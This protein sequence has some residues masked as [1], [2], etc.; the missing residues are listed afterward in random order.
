MKA[1]YLQGYNA[2]TERLSMDL[3]QPH[4]KKPAIILDL[5]ETVLDNSPFWAYTMLHNIPLPQAW[6]NKA[7]SEWVNYEKAQAVPGAKKFLDYANSRGVEIFYVSDRSESQIAATIKTLKYNKIPQAIPSHMLFRQ[8]G[9]HGKT[10]RFAELEKKYNVL[11]YFGDNLGDF[12]PIFHLSLAQRDTL[13]QKYAA[14]FGTRFIIF[15]NPIYGSWENAAYHYQYKLNYSQR[16]EQLL[17]ELK[18]FNPQKM[19]VSPAA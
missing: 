10:G 16:Q 9:M 11:M 2:T 4:A 5:D 18:V 19:S 7:W 8:K 17:K 6:Y 13:V 14:D 3:K 15:P 1:L 12:L